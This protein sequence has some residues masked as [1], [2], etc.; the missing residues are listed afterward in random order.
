MLFRSGPQQRPELVQFVARD[1]F[2]QILQDPFRGR[3][4]HVRAEQPHFQFF[5]KVRIDAPSR[6]PVPEI[7]R[8][9]RSAA[10]EAGAHHG[11]P[12]GNA[13]QRQAQIIAFANDYRM[14]SFVVIPT[15]SLLLLMRRPGAP[16]PR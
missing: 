7:T 14:M 8:Q 13:R 6:Q 11:Q 16:P 15:M 9:R 4:T 2:A 10:V 5:K 1:P 3:E 12:R